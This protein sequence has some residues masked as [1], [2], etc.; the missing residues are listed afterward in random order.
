MPDL[1]KELKQEP[2]KILKVKE[3]IKLV[4]NLEKLKEIGYNLREI[5]DMVWEHK[6]TISGIMRG[7]DNFPIS[8][9]KAQLLNENIQEVFN[10]LK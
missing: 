9:V 8:Y 10:K 4:K 3:R 2:L 7:R 5:G 1:Q 6:N